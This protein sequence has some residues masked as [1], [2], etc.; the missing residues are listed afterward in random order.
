MASQAHSGAAG[1]GGGSE[2]PGGG[3]AAPVLVGNVGQEYVQATLTTM[4]PLSAIQ[5]GAGSLQGVQS[6]H[7]GCVA[8]PHNSKQRDGGCRQHNRWAAFREHSS[9]LPPPPSP[10]PCCGPPPQDIQAHGALQDPRCRPLIG[11]TDQLGLTRCV[12][13]S[14]FRGQCVCS[15]VCVCSNVVESSV[16]FEQFCVEQCAA[17]PLS[18]QLHSGAVHLR[19]SRSCS[20]SA[21]CCQSPTSHT[22]THAALWCHPQTGPAPTDRLPLPPGTPLPCRRA[23][24]HRHVLTAA[25]RELLARIATMQP[26]RLLQLLEVWWA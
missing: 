1:G 25:A 23:E 6:Q 10:P 7:G 4:D 22:A 15:V 19:R 8:R 24:A 9:P 5:V 14:V 18:G 3:G 16:W 17:L 2:L 20:L 13:G 21:S 26:D 12:L 11:L